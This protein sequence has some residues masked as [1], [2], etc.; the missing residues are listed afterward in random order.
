DE[1]NL[2]NAHDMLFVAAAGNSGLPNDSFKFYP[3]SYNAP[4]VVA[5]A[6]TTNQDGLAYFSN[7]GANTVHLGAPG[8]DIVST[9]PNNGY[10]MASGTSMATPHV[11][12]AAMLVLSRC[13]LGTADLK[14]AILSSAEPVPAL[15]GKT[16]T[17]GRLDVN[18][19]MRTCL[20]APAVPVLSSLNG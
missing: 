15:A 7:Y 6:A 13:A 3:A 12:G 20:E 5:V 4:N 2:A 10:L 11:S 18:G 17:G 9:A 8:V 16:V 1:I 19:A 14:T